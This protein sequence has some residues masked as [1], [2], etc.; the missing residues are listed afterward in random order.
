VSV[1]LQYINPPPDV[2]NAIAALNQA[3][4]TWKPT[5]VQVP[6]DIPVPAPAPRSAAQ[7]LSVCEFA[8]D[9]GKYE[10][11]TL[12]LA[13]YMTVALTFFVVGFCYVTRL[14]RLPAVALRPL[15]GY[16]RSKGSLKSPWSNQ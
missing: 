3:C 4:S 14:H 6:H 1:Q 8:R 10:A 2:P 16:V 5:E 7:E 9:P 11:N 15:V 13:L 12:S